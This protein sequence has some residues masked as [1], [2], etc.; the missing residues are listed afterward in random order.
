M[1][2]KT[3]RKTKKEERKTPELR[4]TYVN[5]KMKKEMRV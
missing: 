3:Q 5:G 2:R 4:I 1:G